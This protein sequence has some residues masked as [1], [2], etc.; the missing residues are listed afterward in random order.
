MKTLFLVC[1]LILL[2]SCTFYTE[3]QSEVLSQTVYATRDS[4]EHGRFEL[5]EKYSELTTR[6]VKPPKKRVI[7]APVLENLPSSNSTIIAPS[8]LTIHTPS[9]LLTE[10][11]RVIIVP[12][13]FKNDPVVAINSLEYEKLLQD[14]E[15]HKQLQK[16]YDNLTKTQK[17]VEEELIKQKQ[18]YDQMVIDLNNMKAK[19]GEKDAAIWIRNFIILVMSLVMGAGVYLRIKGIL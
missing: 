9:P 1:G 12:E 10:K 14:Q 19:L 13:R 8:S 15:I 16:D 2:T 18:M 17:T 6:I 4:L 11:R 3:K 7:I 5:A